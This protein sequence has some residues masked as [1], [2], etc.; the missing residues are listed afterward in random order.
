MI[1]FSHV[2]AGFIAVLVGYASSA[3]IVVQAASAAGASTAQ[4]GSWLWALGIGMALTSIGLSWYYRAPLLTAWSTAGAALLA[5]SL[6]GVPLADAIGVFLFSSLLLTLFGLL[7]WIEILLRWVP[8][9]VAAAM[10]AGVLLR[11]GLQLFSTLADALGLTLLML[12]VWVAGR[13]WQPNFAAL[14]SLAVGVL[15][16]A[17]QGQVRGGVIV[18]DFALPVW[19]APSFTGSHL[20]GIGLPL[21]L[22]TMASQ[23]VPGL[24]VLRSNGYDTPASPPLAVTGLTGLLLAPFGGFAY[25]LAAITAAICMSPDA[26]P[27]KER[28]YLAAIWAGAFYAL[29]GLL[30]L[31]LVTAFAALPPALLAAMAGIA[32]LGT[33][34]G[35]LVTAFEEPSERDAA[36]LTFL[37]TASG[38]SLGGIGSAFWGLT[39]G[40]LASAIGRRLRR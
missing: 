31:T 27:V 7:G 34:S 10:L 21:F 3:V 24:A 19:T 4:V 16:C 35:S 20:I 15:L 28:R 12:A 17:L 36:L 25:N 11:F 22:V 5:T 30:G 26:D 37:C 29:S 14:A 38:L 32:L 8:R 33:L 1:R 13:R 18:L 9:A 23:N 40:V 39:A 6:P 2:S